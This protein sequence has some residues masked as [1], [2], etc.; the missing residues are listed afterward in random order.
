M[1]CVNDSYGEGR[2]SLAEVLENGSSATQSK[3]ELLG[4]W[5]LNLKLEELG[6]S[7]ARRV[8]LVR[9]RGAVCVFNKLSS[10]GELSFAEFL[11]ESRIT[12][13]SLE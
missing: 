10:N 5:L 3:I 1:P 4:E 7:R 11:G 9:C 8:S 13:D 6:E 2:L 12:L